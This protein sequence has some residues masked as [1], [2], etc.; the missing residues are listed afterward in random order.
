MFALKV[1]FLKSTSANKIDVF[2]IPKNFGGILVYK[3]KGFSYLEFAI[4][5]DEQLAYSSNMINLDD[6]FNMDPQ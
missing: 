4:V 3:L 2:S 1:C 5:Y 6:S